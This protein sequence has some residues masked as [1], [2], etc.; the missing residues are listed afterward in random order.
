MEKFQ[1][2][3]IRWPEHAHQT[4]HPPLFFSGYNSTFP[5]DRWV[6]NQIGKLFC[7]AAGVGQEELWHTIFVDR[8]K[9]CSGGR[10]YCVL[11]QGVAG[12]REVYSAVIEMCG[13]MAVCSMAVDSEWSFY[14]ASWDVCDVHKHRMGR[15]SGMSSSDSFLPHTFED[16]GRRMF[17]PL[18]TSHTPNKKWRCLIVLCSEQ[19][20]WPGSTASLGV[21]ETRLDR[22]PSRMLQVYHVSYGRD[23]EE[24]SHQIL[25]KPMTAGETVEQNDYVLGS[26]RFKCHLSQDQEMSLDKPPQSRTH[27]KNLQASM[28]KWLECPS[29]LWE[30]HVQIPNLPLDD[31]ETVALSG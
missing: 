15:G 13:K 18:L 23:R 17:L 24:M 29:T 8:E 11:A 19:L 9:N 16:I 2:V 25:S 4:L 5:V 6:I 28:E 26:S 14:S 7:K 1:I 10:L 20:T 21:F 27:P 31:L 22:H 3:P 12:N 30:S